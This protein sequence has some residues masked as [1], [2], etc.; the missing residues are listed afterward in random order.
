[1]E[2]PS[3]G[4]GMPCVYPELNTISR[5]AQDSAF[6]EVTGTGIMWKQSHTAL[7]DQSWSRVDRKK[8]RR[9][10]GLPTQ[11]DSHLSHFQPMP[12]PSQNDDDSSLVRGHQ[13]FLLSHGLRGTVTS[14]D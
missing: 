10:K 6:S 4:L 14:R 8:E 5:A 1:M 11:P 2:E 12:Q 7:S 9:N 3:T 13:L